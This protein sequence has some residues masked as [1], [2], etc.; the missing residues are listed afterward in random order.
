TTTEEGIITVTL[1]RDHN[2]IL[3]QVSDNGAGFAI[4][5][6][7]ASSFGMRMVKIFAQKLKAELDIFNKGGAC[8][9]MRITK[10]KIT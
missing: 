6:S 8:V 2:A 3:L 9:S 4:G 10:F 5:P 7:A 1:K